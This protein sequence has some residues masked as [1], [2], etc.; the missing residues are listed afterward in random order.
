[1]SSYSKP[2]SSFQKHILYQKQQKN[3]EKNIKTIHSKESISIKTVNQT[4][5][6]LTQNN[7]TSFVNNSKS[8]SKTSPPGRYPNTP[9]TKIITPPIKLENSKKAQITTETNQI[10]S[11]T[12]QTTITSSPSLS[13]KNEKNVTG[14]GNPEKLKN[15]NTR[16]F[17]LSVSI[18]NKLHIGNNHNNNKWRRNNFPV[19]YGGYPSTGRISVA[20]TLPYFGRQYPTDASFYYHSGLYPPHYSPVH[21]PHLRH[22]HFTHQQFLAV[23]PVPQTHP[24]HKDIT[25]N[26]ISNLRRSRS[27]HGSF[28]NKIFLPHHQQLN[29]R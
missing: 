3:Q 22:H 16:D 12:S 20:S 21:H 5:H 7:N 4:S 19:F 24:Y 23:S 6:Q 28:R 18:G 8:N 29:S 17:S 1:M 26:H 2:S 14:L 25:I 11:T 10:T 15:T 27:A 13:T 9:P